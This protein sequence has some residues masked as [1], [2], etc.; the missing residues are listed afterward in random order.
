[1]PKYIAVI[2]TPGYLPD[3]SEPPPVFDSAQ[4]AWQYLAEERRRDEDAHFNDPDD[5]D[6]QGYSACVDMLDQHAAADLPGV[7]QGD[8]SG[9][10]GD[11]D[12]G[13]AYCVDIA[14]EE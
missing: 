11:H 10:E 9:H 4:E 6:M 1:M 14:E 2:N 3:S 5:P 8:T 7:V 12:L 13:V